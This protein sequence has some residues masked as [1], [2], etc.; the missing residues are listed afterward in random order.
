MKLVIRQKINKKVVIFDGNHLAYRSH[1]VLPYLKDSKNRLVGCIYGV[2]N[3]LF[4]IKKK[5]V[6]YKIIFA[7]DER[8]TVRKKLFEQYKENR[9]E[10]PDWFEDFLWQ[11][12][13]LKEILSQHNVEQ[14][15]AEGYE[16]D[17]IAAILVNRYKR[18]FE[19]YKN[20]KKED[21]DCVLVT[22]DSDW[23]QLVDDSCNVRYMNP[24]KNEILTDNEV[25]KQYNIDSPYQLALIKSIK[26]D[27]SDNIPKIN[28]FPSKIASALVKS[29]KDLNPLY[30]WL[31]TLDLDKDTD[32]PKKWLKVLLDKKEQVVL[33]YKLVKLGYLVPEKM[34]IVRGVENFDEL[35]KLYKEYSFENYLKDLNRLYSIRKLK[36]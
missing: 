3:S 27:K 16:A 30:E 12:D 19:N 9:S 5:Y 7:W 2:L 14:Y 11:L 10:K 34:K 1:Y 21:W 20:K 29:F 15:S 4:S 17:D 23:K 28:R 24:I 22:S 36:C 25:S 33:N 18:T 6:N 31:E 13:R 35:R 8:P 32:L 26:G